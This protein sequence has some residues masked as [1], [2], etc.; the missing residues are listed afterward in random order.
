MTE[1][2][3]ML[4]EMN[5]GETS[6]TV[7]SDFAERTGIEDAELFSQVFSTCRE[8]GGDIVKASASASE[9][10]GEK[11]K[12]ENDMRALLSQKKSEGFIIG[13]MPAVIILFLRIVAPDYIAV[14]YRN[15]GGV[16]LMTIALA[17]SG[18]AYY[19]I[20][21]LSG[22]EGCAYD[23]YENRLCLIQGISV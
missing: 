21:T 18:F 4:K 23:A 6:D 11:I 5:D 9:M 1:I 13:V 19:L 22:F 20:K 17:A 7:L 14:L 15:P 16:I 2:R 3:G 12:I 8:T 10:L